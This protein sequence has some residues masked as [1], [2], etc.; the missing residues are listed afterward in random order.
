M[1]A[2]K[3]VFTASTIPAMMFMNSAADFQ[4][5]RKLDKEAEMK[6]RL[7]ELAKEPVDITPKNGEN[8]AWTGQDLNSF[9]DSWGMKPVVI[10]G[11]LDIKK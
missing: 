11:I 7:T 3:F 10:N 8:F 5:R 2:K 4:K 1:Y 6:R 9:E